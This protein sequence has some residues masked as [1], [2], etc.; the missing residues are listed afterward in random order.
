MLSVR[1][2]TVHCNQSHEYGIGMTE[3]HAS[4]TR[5]YVLCISK[6]APVWWI[7]MGNWDRTLWNYFNFWEILWNNNKLHH[8]QVEIPCVSDHS[9]TQGIPGLWMQLHSCPILP[10]MPYLSLKFL[11]YINISCKMVV[12]KFAFCLWLVSYILYTPESKCLCFVFICEMCEN[13]VL[14]IRYDYLIV[15]SSYNYLHNMLCCFT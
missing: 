9:H 8:L 1:R 11:D 4:I 3:S 12:Q 5:N 13:E 14:Q 7:E 15:A 6:S 10:T 2:H